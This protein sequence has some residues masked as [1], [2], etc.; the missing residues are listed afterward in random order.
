MPRRINNTLVPRNPTART[1]A[2]CRGGAHQKSRSSAR[3]ERREALRGHL[4]DWR[5]ELE[6][7]RQLSQASPIEAGSDSEPADQLGRP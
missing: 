5:E 3:Q 6:F 1:L 7:E 4:D 2:N